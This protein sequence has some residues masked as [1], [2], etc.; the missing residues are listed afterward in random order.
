MARYIPSSKYKACQKEIEM[1]GRK[2]TRTCI[3]FGPSPYNFTFVLL[4]LSLLWLS[5]LKFAEERTKDVTPSK[6]N[7]H[8]YY[9]IYIAA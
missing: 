7:H 9:N 8:F 6:L 5:V 4:I 1:C 2:K 3:C